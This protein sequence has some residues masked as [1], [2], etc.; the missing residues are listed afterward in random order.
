MSGKAAQSGGGFCVGA[1]GLA[2]ADELEGQLRRLA[3]HL[4]HLVGIADARQLDDDAVL[5]LP[6][7]RGFGDARAVDAILDDLE[8][9]VDGAAHLGVEARLRECET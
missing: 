8:R 2:L 9:L 1:V 5:A 6:L 4:D 3:D 7:D